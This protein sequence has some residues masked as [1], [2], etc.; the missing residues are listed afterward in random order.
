MSC[1]FL[2]CF[3]Y[4]LNCFD[5]IVIFQS[6]TLAQNYFTKPNSPLKESLQDTTQTLKINDVAHNFQKS[7]GILPNLVRESPERSRNL[8]SK[9]M[10]TL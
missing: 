2:Q 10:L 6:S 7:H 5:I 9:I 8:L 3:T 1:H 4:I